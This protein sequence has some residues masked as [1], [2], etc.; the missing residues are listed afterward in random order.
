MRKIINSTINRLNMTRTE[1]TQ[2][3]SALI[4]SQGL[5]KS[6]IARRAGIANYTF[7]MKIRCKPNYLFT[8]EELNR[9]TNVLSGIGCEILALL[10]KLEQE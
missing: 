9:I 4:K 6:D 2:L 10:N 5:N 1:K 8:D 3:I 7:N